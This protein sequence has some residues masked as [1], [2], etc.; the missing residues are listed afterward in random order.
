VKQ[1]S[2]GFYGLE[3]LTRIKRIVAGYTEISAFFRPKQLKI[4]LIYLVGI[5]YFPSLLKICVIC[6][7]CERLFAQTLKQVPWPDKSS[8]TLLL[9]FSPDLSFSKS[10]TPARIQA[11]PG[12]S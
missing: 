10:K 4:A 9:P 1:L 12:I 8:L 7:I 6:E 5:H 11:P 3:G 2:Q